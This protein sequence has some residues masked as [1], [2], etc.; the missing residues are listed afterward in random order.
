ML[1]TD[2]HWLQYLHV[3]LS[4][5]HTTFRFHFAPQK[6][7]TQKEVK[8]EGQDL[9]QRD[10]EKANRELR[11]FTLKGLNGSYWIQ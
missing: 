6:T 4:K 9:K 2:W 3:D 5:V 1:V 11:A 7:Q 8:Y 10:K